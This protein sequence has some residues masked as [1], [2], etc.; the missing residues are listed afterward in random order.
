MAAG[1]CRCRAGF[2][3]AA[4]A[5]CDLADGYA[6]V[7][8]QGVCERCV[9][10]CDG[11]RGQCVWD[12]LAA[13]PR[14]DCQE[15]WAGE[16]CA[17]CAPGFVGPACAACPEDGCGPGGACVWSASAQTPVCSCDEDSVYVHADPEDDASPCAVCRGGLS[18]LTCGA[19]P[20]CPAGAF[21]AEPAA[22]DVHCP[23][24]AHHARLAGFAN[25]TYDCYPA[26]LASILD[27]QGYRPDLPADLQVEALRVDLH[28]D[29]LPP[30]DTPDL[31]LTLY[32][33]G[34][35]VGAAFLGALVAFVFVARTR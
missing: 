5:E 34:G 35:V 20:L 22:G 21:C 27:S 16:T 10:A 14:C 24:L 29:P 31:L 30:P 4:C 12:A 15:G 17:E 23:C 8:A 1:G 33:G 3:G 19:C 6:G 25:E 9:P 18:P 13:A 2:R 11:E 7:P 28:V 26:A 32:A